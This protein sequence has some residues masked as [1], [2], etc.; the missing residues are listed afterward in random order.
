MITC[1][2]LAQMALFL[3]MIAAPIEQEPGII[4]IETTG[5][6]TVV[7]ERRG[8]LFCKTTE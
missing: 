1:L 2:S 5:N 7:Y 3:N 4:R 6:D 8:D